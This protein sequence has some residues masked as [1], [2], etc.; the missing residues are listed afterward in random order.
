MSHTRQDDGTTGAL[1]VTGE[2]YLPDTPANDVEATPVGRPGPLGLA[3]RL[4]G[5][6]GRDAA[7]PPG[8]DGLLPAR[9]L[10]DAGP[11][12]V[13]RAGGAGGERVRGRRAPG[14]SDRRRPG[15]SFRP[16]GDAAGRHRELGA[17]HAG[18]GPGA[19][20]ARDR[21]PGTAAGVLQ[22]ALPPAVAGRGRRCRAAG[23]ARA[24]LRP[25]PLG[26]QPRLRRRRVRRR[27]AGRTPLRGPV[28]HRRADDARVRRHR[29]R[30]SAR[31]PAVRGHD[32][33]A[34][35]ARPPVRP[36]ARTTGASFASR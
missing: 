11:G 27:R 17:P 1:P 9:D 20:D 6:V 8:R 26:D 13:T 14:R 24:R 36:A 10:P 7:Q 19:H 2:I 31:D 23:R 28:R 18:A 34:A 3:A 29:V 12:T 30:G 22:R 32:R 4:L 21:G 25:P 5:P 35:A 33:D 15:R 16:A